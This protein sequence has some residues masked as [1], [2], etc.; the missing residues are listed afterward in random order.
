MTLN[1]CLKKVFLTFPSIKSLHSSVL[2]SPILTFGYFKFSISFQYSQQLN[3]LLVIW[4]RDWG[5]SKMI[6]VV[7]NLQ[8]SRTTKTEPQ[9]DHLKPPH[10]RTPSSY[11]A[12]CNLPAQ[13]ARKI[14]TLNLNQ[15]CYFRLNG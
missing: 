3:I 11:R 7:S 13:H 5:V 4:G 9:L 6:T 2:D 15:F 12:S 10:L 1:H 8:K 14:N